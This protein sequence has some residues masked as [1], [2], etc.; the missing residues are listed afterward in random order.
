MTFAVDWALNI[1]NQPV[2][3]ESDTG[4]ET[5]MVAEIVF[6]APTMVSGR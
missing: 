6:A 5:E 4:Q 2:P 1:D 3:K